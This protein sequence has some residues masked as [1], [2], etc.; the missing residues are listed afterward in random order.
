MAKQ[1]GGGGSWTTAEELYER[2]DPGFVD[3]I[4]RITDAEKLGAFAARWYADPRPE[5]RRLLRD[6]L[7]LPLNAL[8]HEAL[9]KRL[10]KLAEA[11]GDD[12]IVGRFMVLFDRSIRRQRRKCYHYD[13]KS[14]KSVTI[15]SLIVPPG[16][17]M[18]RPNNPRPSRH[19][20]RLRLYSVHTR[21]YLRR[22]AWRY[23]RKL[24]RRTPDRYVLAM[25]QALPLYT[26]DDVAN[27]ISLLDNWG[28]VHVLFHYSDALLSRPTGWTLTEGHTLGDLKPE[29]MFAPL[30]KAN[31]DALLGL[32]QGDVCRTVRQ[33]AIQLLRRDH[34]EAFDRL[35]L[36]TLLNWLSHPEPELVTLA[37]DL[38]RVRG[39]LQDVPVDRWLQ[40]VET[41]QPETLEALCGMIAANVTADRVTIA[42][43]VVLAKRR[44]SALVRLGLTWLQGKTPSTVEDCHALLTLR[45]AESDTMRRELVQWA[46]NILVASPLFEPLWV[47]EWI[48]SRHSEVR[49]EGWAWMLADGRVRDHVEIWKRLLESP[50]DDIRLPIVAD[51]EARVLKNQRAL[52]EDGTLDPGMVRFLW[53]TVLLNIHRGGRS[54]PI[55]VRQMVRRLEKHPMEATVLLPILAAALRSASGPEFRAGLVGV[56][57]MIESVAGA[58]ATVRAAFPELDPSPATLER[59][60]GTFV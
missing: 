28:L 22:R 42:Q 31:P 59:G 32:V 27:G 54:K 57:S 58:E 36:E 48:D 21:N 25:L 55:V 15:E 44:P 46:R 41:A 60:V 52:T 2:G 43:A 20:E 6:Y 9:V 30:W 35:S 51:L 18:P 26:N 16:S 45:D 29:P 34:P 56:V 23:F 50:Y 11:A 10:Y 7:N 49:A 17:T 8:R 24:G 47:L 13:R 4:R 14:R 3:E 37:A 19:Y 33:W 1:Q 5:A 39:G 12:E 38:L 40:L 53:A